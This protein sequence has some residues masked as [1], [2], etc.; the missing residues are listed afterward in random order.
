M[1]ISFG[2]C[3]CNTERNSN[4]WQH[5][6][7][8]LSDIFKKEIKLLTFESFKEEHLFLQKRE[9]DIY[10]ASPD[11]AIFLMEKDYIP[12]FRLA[13]EE[14]KLILV[15]LKNSRKNKK[16]LK[17]GLPELNFFYL[18]ILLSS[19]PFEKIDIV[20]VKCFREGL[21]KLYDKEI[22]YL[23]LYERFF[24]DLP[25]NQREFIKIEETLSVP[26]FHFLMFKRD[27]YKQYK[28]F[29]DKVENLDYFERT[30]KDEVQRLESILKKIRFLSI[31]FRNKS[32]LENL[33]DHHG[34]IIAAY[35][36]RFIFTNQG[37]LDVTGYSLEEILNMSPLDL[38][39]EEDRSLAE[40]ILK[41]RLK[42]QKFSFFYP[43]L[44]IKHKSG[45]VIHLY[46]YTQTIYYNNKPTGLIIGID[47]TREKQLEILNKILKKINEIIIKSNQE[48]EIYENLCK[49][50]IDTFNLELIWIGK[51]E[52]EDPNI[53]LVYSFGKE[54]DFPP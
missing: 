26:F 30:S 31:F 10:L 43:N 33:L 32:I 17:V 46:C 3:P 50:L 34:L 53:T 5:F 15:R 47:I 16:V 13:G 29:I 21:E 54:R 42:G 45:K 23:F 18:G 48:K 2:I 22:D 44:R 27:F 24:N 1:S 39:Y 38:V 41:R 37:G 25:H 52:K 7:K 40:K 14:D 20:F 51:L 28:D 6:T 19:L 8:L 36:D 35:Q 11:V 4:Y 12:L 9:P 49:T